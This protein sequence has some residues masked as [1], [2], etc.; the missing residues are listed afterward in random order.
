MTT[1]TT[2]PGATAPAVHTDAQLLERSWKVPIGL[3]VFAL[4]AIILFVVLGRDG[5]S[6]FSFT[7]SNANAVQ[8]PTLPLGA[9]ATGI[10]VSVIAVLMAAGAAV[11]V[12]R[13][14][15]VPLWYVAIYTLTLVIGFL[16]WTTTATRSTS[17]GC[18]SDLSR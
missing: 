3:G 15:H 8:L 12:Q 10:V 17:P 2:S 1:A 4:V 13:R 9:R 16:V 11:L 5:Q 14:V 6:V 7:A 18:S